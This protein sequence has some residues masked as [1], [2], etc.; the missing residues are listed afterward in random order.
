MGK[1]GNL[2]HEFLELHS[3][4]QADR[5]F[6]TSSPNPEFYF[7]VMLWKLMR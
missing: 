6:K 5:T 1:N 7:D 2:D 3:G 4:I